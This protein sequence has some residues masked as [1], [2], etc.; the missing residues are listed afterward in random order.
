MYLS[1]EA[2]NKLRDLF[3]RYSSLFSRAD[4]YDTL[5]LTQFFLFLEDFNFLDK[6][7][8]RVKAELIFY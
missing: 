5:E 3:V 4:N 2:Y 7:F 8:G 6:N 1:E